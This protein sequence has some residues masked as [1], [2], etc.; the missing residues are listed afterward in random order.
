MVEGSV[1]QLTDTYQ[2]QDFIE[3]RAAKKCYD[4]ADVVVVFNPGI[5]ILGQIIE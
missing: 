1:T 3:Y 5:R 2:D 4:I